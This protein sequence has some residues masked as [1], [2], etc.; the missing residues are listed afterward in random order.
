MPIDLQ[1]L[2][3][4]S[5]NAYMLLDRELR[6]VAA[7]PAYL[8]VTA[9]RLEDL[10]GRYLFDV[11]PDPTSDG[12]LRA[13]FAR[14][15][16]TKEADTIAL[17][18]YRVPQRM[19]DGSVRDEDRFWSATHVPLLDE[20]GQVVHILQHTVDVT[21]VERL[22]AAIDSH[23]DGDHGPARRAEQGVLG[24]ARVVQERNLLL[25]EE[26]EHLRRLFEQAPGFVAF[27]RGPEQ[28]FE[29]ANA[30]YLALVGHRPI[31]GKPL[32]EALPELEGQGF[33]DLVD[34]VY[35]SGEPF[36]GR[37]MRA[38]L[39][40]EA[41]TPPEEVFLDFVYQPIV[42][43]AGAVTGIFVSGYDITQQRRAETQ[44]RFLAETIPQQVWTARPDGELDFV[45]ARVA[46][47]FGQSAA[48]ILG[49]GWQAFIHPDDLPRTL[50]AWSLALQTGTTYEIEFRLRRHDGQWRWHLGRALSM[51]DAN[52][53]VQRWYG[54]N[55][56]IDEAR[57]IRDE[58][59]DRTT[60]E[61]QLIGIVA[62]DLRSP[63]AGIKLSA[64]LLMRRGNL[65]VQQGQLVGRVA[66]MTDRATRLIRDLL[67]FSQARSVG[68][69]P[70]QPR[71][72]D[73]RALTRQ[74]VDEA[75]LS[76]PE[77]EAQVE[78]HGETTGRW[79][80]D[81][82]AQVVG[83][84]VGNAF[85]H[86]PPGTPVRVSTRVIDDRAEIVVHNEGPPIP[87]GDRARLFAPFQRGQ[88]SPATPARSVGLGLYIAHELVAAH[89]G[90]IDVESVAG[91]GTT[92]TVR[93]PR[94]A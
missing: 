16:A 24:R 19:P 52:G 43:R 82:L 18:R 36:V 80:D 27:L 63:L 32:R 70:V 93:L 3:E 21:E 1:Q 56:D 5:P 30:A 7:N 87:E 88:D 51:P 76:H 59:H 22:R 45:N 11:F 92:F 75:Q 81:R 50:S 85:Q 60:F 13:S 37:G 2:F 29:L 58:L 9:S 47:Y 28:V 31:L 90:T 67:D 49:A 25:V 94:E 35:A 54:T 69:I 10:L 77:R 72:A 57:R 61:K 64:S 53:V 83:N 39:Q 65:D 42:D 20:D 91:R 79:D 66:S 46:E 15:L 40:R 4:H 26:R 8:G 74:A 23:H 17:V 41:G 48:A 38:L 34:R 78:H 73:L 62:H 12:V 68:R 6:Y 33:F 14:V 44:Y 84:L 71:V 89:G 55:T 86:G